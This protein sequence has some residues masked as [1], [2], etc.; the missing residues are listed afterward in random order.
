MA[1]GTLI[2]KLCIYSLPYSKRRAIFQF[3]KLV[4]S[5]YTPG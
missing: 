5:I 2:M 4:R 3:D 1:Q